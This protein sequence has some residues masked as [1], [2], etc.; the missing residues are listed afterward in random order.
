MCD[1]TNPD[2]VGEERADDQDSETWLLELERDELQPLP[3]E[4]D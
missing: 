2:G 3:D 4:D 1:V